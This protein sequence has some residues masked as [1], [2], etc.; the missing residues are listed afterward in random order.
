M[1][2][3]TA[4]RAPG[5]RAWRLAKIT[6]TRYLSLENPSPV[7]ARE[8]VARYVAALSEGS[9]QE[10]GSP[11]AGFR[12][13]RKMAQNLGEFCQ[14]LKGPDDGTATTS[15]GWPY[16]SPLAEAHALA[17][18][19]LEQ[20]ASLEEAALRPALVQQLVE[21][22]RTFPEASRAV[23]KFLAAALYHRLVFDLGEPLEAAATGRL[24]LAEGLAAIQQVIAGAA[25]ERAGAVPAPAAWQGLEGWLW[26]SKVLEEMLEYFT[27]TAMAEK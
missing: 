17:S 16:P 15:S 11:L 13:T 26:T 5:T 4:R 21:I 9:A 3:S 8:V 2:T 27:P 25:E 19:W 14:Q 7:Q 18:A 22:L 24:P 20:A 1:G 10:A 6:A 12:L 23:R